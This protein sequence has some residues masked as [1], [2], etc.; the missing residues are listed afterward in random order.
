MISLAMVIDH[1][2]ST[3]CKFPQIKS[4]EWFVT[5]IKSLTTVGLEGTPLHL[6]LYYSMQGKALVKTTDVLMCITHSST[7]K[8]SQQGE[9]FLVSS[10]LISLCFAI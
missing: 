10:R 5:S 2:Y 8:A 7:M 9:S 4:K 6:C 1:I 3:M